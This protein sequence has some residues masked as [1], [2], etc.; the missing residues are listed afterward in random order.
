MAVF[1]ITSIAVSTILYQQQSR[2]LIYL[3]ERL[4]EVQTTNSQEVVLPTHGPFNEERG[5]TINHVEI[6]Q[7]N[8]RAVNIPNQSSLFRSFLRLGIMPPINDPG[9]VGLTV[10]DRN[11]QILYQHRRPFAIESF[12]EFHPLIWEAILVREDQQF[13]PWESSEN[14]VAI[15]SRIVSAVWNNLINLIPG[16]SRECPT[17]C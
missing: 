15:P 9:V 3:N 7:R 4:N 12:E 6:L 2:F 11:G 1:L 8:R 16:I 14:N 13:K 10:L 5:Y 17:D